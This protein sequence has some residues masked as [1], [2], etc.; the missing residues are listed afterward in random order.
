MTSKDSHF[1][2]VRIL[3]D[4][5]EEEK[6]NDIQTK[7]CLDWAFAGK[8]R[9]T[10]EINRDAGKLKSW[11]NVWDHWIDSKSNDPESDEAD[12]TLQ[13]DGTTL[14]E[15]VNV[16][17]V[18]GAETKYEEL[19]KDL[20]VD[21]IGKK[22]KRSSIVLKADDS[23][24]KVEGMVVKVGGW[25]QGMLKIGDKLTI[26]RWQRRPVD[27]HE[28]EEEDDNVGESTRTRNDWVRVFRLGTATLPCKEICSRT[29]GKNGTNITMKDDQQIEWRVIEEYYY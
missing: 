5:Y 2:D 26:E 14:E 3:R 6:G 29:T 15:G 17:A 27:Q 9:I 4:K 10:K 18:S 8:S 28:D 24:I 1:V 19:W 22:Q 20:P 12:M 16:D 13:E 7:A 21:P 11:H 23:E 25:C